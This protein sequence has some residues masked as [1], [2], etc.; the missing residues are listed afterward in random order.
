[1]IFRSRVRAPT[2]DKTV[3]EIEDG[4]SVY[5]SEDVCLSGERS[6]DFETQRM[7]DGSLT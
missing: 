2:F 3:I 7:L 6:A 4:G 5:E 1:M